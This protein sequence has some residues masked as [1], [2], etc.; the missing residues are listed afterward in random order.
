MGWICYLDDPS[1]YRDEEFDW[2]CDFFHFPTGSTL[3]YSW[4]ILSTKL[5]SRFSPLK[6]SLFSPNLAFLWMLLRLF[7][8]FMLW[9]WLFEWIEIF[10]LLFFHWLEVFANEDM[11]LWLYSSASNI[12]GCWIGKLFV[13]SDELLFEY[14]LTDLAIFFLLT[15]LGEYAT[16]WFCGRGE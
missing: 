1:M 7:D 12:M 13:R 9:C 10:E 5:C 16:N 15:G 2:E 4:L 3:D 8:A 6:F 14:L 11:F